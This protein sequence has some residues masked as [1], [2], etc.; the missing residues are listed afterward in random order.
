MKMRIFW[1][2]LA[3]MAILL[4]SQPSKQVVPDRWNP[5]REANGV[6]LTGERARLWDCAAKNIVVRSGRRSLKTE[7]VAK[8]KTIL[9]LR[10]KSNYGNWRALYLAPTQQQAQNIVWEDWKKLIPPLWIDPRRGGKISESLHFIRTWWGAELWC[11][12]AD[13]PSRAEGGDWDW[14]VND[15]SA[16]MKPGVWLEHIMPMVRSRNGI[17]YHV[18]TPDYRGPGAKD[19]KELCEKAQLSTDPNWAHFWWPSWEV[20]TPE[21]IA[22]A[23]LDTT[24]E[25]FRQEF[26]GEW[27]SAPGKAYYCFS[28]T[29]H[30]KDSPV[31]K[32]KDIYIFCDFNRS[33][34]NWGMGQV[35]NHKT[36]PGKY[37]YHAT[38]QLFYQDAT[39]E[40]M[41][42]NT[43]EVLNGIDPSYLTNQKRIHF[44]GDFSGTQERVEATASAWEQVEQ[45]FPGADFMYQTQGHV[46][47][48][49]DLVNTTLKNAA[50]IHSLEVDKDF[51]ELIDDLE[52]VKTMDL[53]GQKNKVGRRTHS[54]DALGYWI[55][56]HQ[57]SVKR[58]GLYR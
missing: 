54:S 38:T 34:H 46:S 28:K 50:G 7:I 52:Y 2:L 3:A 49:I 18:G 44:C 17:V 23:K 47:D 43:K 19:Y 13:K 15:E 41:C 9:S 25:L 29:D 48:R 14:V 37:F 51:K 20:M 53:I 45:A 56:Q 27:I 4:P 40:V 21:M 57:E 24:D 26:G 8:R 35:S 39:I 12:G 6:G 22:E 32:E 33:Y 36:M 30:V 16:D 5:L 11:I 10:N 55:A 58:K 42:K 31:N 1:I